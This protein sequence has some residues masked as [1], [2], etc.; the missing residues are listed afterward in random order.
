[1]SP[2]QTLHCCLSFP[3]AS[4][5]LLMPIS[6]SLLYLRLIII[7]GLTELRNAQ[8][9]IWQNLWVC[10]GCATVWSQ[11]LWCSHWG[12]H[13]MGALLRG[14]ERKRGPSWRNEVTGHLSCL[15]LFLYTPSFCFHPQRTE[16]E[17]PDIPILRSAKCTRP[18]IKGTRL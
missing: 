15:G 18:R 4:H 16:E 17:L 13:N 12:R 5:R 11:E 8:V 10:W 3:Y 9:I 2:A 1:M 7:I 6:L 14:S